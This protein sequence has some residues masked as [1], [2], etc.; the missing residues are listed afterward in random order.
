MAR[1]GGGPYHR[2]MAEESCAGAGRS[3]ATVL[4]TDLVASTELRSR[5]GEQTAEEIRRQHDRLMSEAI[6]KHRGRL[7]KNLGDGVMA[8]FAGASDALAAAVGIQQALGRH[9]RS[10]ASVVPLEVRIGV[11]AGDVTVE[12]GD[13]FGTPVI[14]AA[15]LC[16]AA[17]GGDRPGRPWRRRPRRAVPAVLGGAAPLRDP[18]VG[19]P[20][21]ALPRRAGPPRP[22]TPGAG[23]RPARSAPFRPRDGALP[24]LR[25]SGRLAL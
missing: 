7:V 2:L 1:L 13:C 25:R 5:L 23:R 24:A 16:A 21:R 18:C 8:T 17:A 9:N 14:E 12:E 15:R 10:S 11:S 6:E 20:A 19:P 3:T 4:F 22:R